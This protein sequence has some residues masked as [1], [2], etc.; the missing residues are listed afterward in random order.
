[1]RLQRHVVFINAAIHDVYSHGTSEFTFNIKVHVA[2]GL[3]I[4]NE[5]YISKFHKILVK[6]VGAQEIL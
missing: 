6:C 5:I 4:Y 2:S 1:M 3:Y